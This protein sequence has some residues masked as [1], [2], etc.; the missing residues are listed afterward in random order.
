MELNDIIS[1]KITFTFFAEEMFEHVE[2][3]TKLLPRFST[4]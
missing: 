1:G 4:S 3:P 2:R